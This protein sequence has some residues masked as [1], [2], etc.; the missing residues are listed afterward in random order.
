[1]PKKVIEVPLPEAEQSGIRSVSD[2]AKEIV[3]A[4]KTH[5]IPPKKERKPRA[6]LSEEQKEKRREN[7]VKARLVKSSKASKAI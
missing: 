7:L 2:V 6:P 3:D 5:M 4:V 1:M